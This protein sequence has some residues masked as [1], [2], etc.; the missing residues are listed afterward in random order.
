MYIRKIV[1]LFSDYDA[2]AY[3]FA[4]EKVENLLI[5]AL[6]RARLRDDGR[7]LAA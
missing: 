3:Q 4:T 1:C 7:R 5:F 2:G 6:C